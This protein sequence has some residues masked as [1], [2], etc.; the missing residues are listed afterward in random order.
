MELKLDATP[1][2]TAEGDWLIVGVT[3]GLDQDRHWGLLD[4]ALQGQ[5]TRLREARDLTGKSGETLVIHDVPGLAAQRL[6]VVGL[7]PA[8]KVNGR[9]VTKSLMTALRM[10]TT[11]D[12]QRVTLAVPTNPEGGIPGEYVSLAAQAAIVAG[13]GQDLYKAE[14]GRFAPAGV[15]LLVNDGDDVAVLKGAAEEGKRIGEAINLAREL[16]NQPPNV[17]YPAS[18]AKRAEGL[19]KENGVKCRVLDLAALKQERMG[20]MLAVAQ[21]SAEDPRLVVLE[22]DGVKEGP[23]LG[24]CGKGVT[25]DSGGLSLKS[26]DNMMTMKCDMAGAA[27]TLAAV[28]AMAQLKLP[29]RVRGLMGLVEN[30][31]S[32]TS[33][34]LGDILT[35]RSGITIENLNTDAEGRLVLADVLNYAL[36]LGVDYLVDLAT[37]TGAVV[38]ALGED[39]TGAFTNNQ[40]WCAK[41]VTAA[42]QSGE[43]V[44]QLPMYDFYAE[45]LKSDVADVKNVGGRWG[46]A[47]TA[48]K[49]LEKFVGGK[50]WV[51]L[52]IAGPAFA[53]SSKPSREGGATGCLVRTLV[54]LGRGMGG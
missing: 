27:T 23:I 51:H 49:F 40:E 13:M 48:A 22:Y 52:D 37:L 46:G 1:W 54:E 28:L 41:V 20:S 30:M 21:G 42:D 43:D 11:R 12:K 16:V 8:E 2:T 14:R 32:G 15:H 7:G 36:D 17:V 24:I 3:E 34:K 53:S 47:I 31:P 4:S 26:N 38:V 39:V 10:V 6:L 35:S 29:V 25:F 33:F 9:G 5:L 44:W 19:A 50:P 18:F 45:L